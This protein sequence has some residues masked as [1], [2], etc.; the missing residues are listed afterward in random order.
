VFRLVRIGGKYFNQLHARG[1]EFLD[2]V[3]FHP[4]GSDT[5]LHSQPDKVELYEAIHGAGVAY[6]PSRL[7]DKRLPDFSPG[8]STDSFEG[9]RW[10]GEAGAR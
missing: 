3:S 10:C 2:L 4:F 8:S 9:C 1:Q 7:R 5:G 6:L